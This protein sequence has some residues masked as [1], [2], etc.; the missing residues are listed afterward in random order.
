MNELGY[1]PLKEII[2]HIGEKGEF[3][4][5]GTGKSFMSMEEKIENLEDSSLG[6][7]G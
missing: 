3:I 1:K 4:D 7:D 6:K 5:T 2:I